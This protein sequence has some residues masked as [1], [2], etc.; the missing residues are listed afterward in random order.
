MTSRLE[1]RYRAVLRVLPPAYRAAWEEEM[2]ATFLESMATEDPEDAEFLAE[3]GRPHWSEVASV[4][5]LAIRLRLPA[6]RLR[7]GGVGAPPRYRLWGDAVRQVALMGL[8]THAVLATVT[9]VNLLWEAGKLPW[10]PPPPWPFPAPGPRAALRVFLIFATV[11]AYLALLSGR[12]HAAW[13]LALLG[14]GSVRAS[15][16]AVGQPFDAERWSL[17]LLDLLLLATLGAFHR[18]APPVRRGPWLAALPVG[19]VL[20]FGATSAEA[21]WH[22]DWPLQDPAGMFAAGLIGAAFAHFAGALRRARRPAAPRSLALALLALGL[23]GMRAVTLSDYVGHAPPA[24][25]ATL[26]S[27][28][29]VEVAGLLAV[30]VPLALL[31]LRTV[32]RLPAPGLP[33]GAG[34][35]SA[36]A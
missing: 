26:L 32:R 35:R 14:I 25:H 28:G 36:G 22:R 6:L 17:L 34:S 5:G 30:G 27:V 11:P 18:D 19:V 12:R 29:L 10:L 20:T 15:A 8:L 4:L 1:E 7:L 3:Y 21:F 2:V 9:V 24:L 33:A 13:L 16:L 23:I 31:A